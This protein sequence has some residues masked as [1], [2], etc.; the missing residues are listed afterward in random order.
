MAIKIGEGNS[1]LRKKTKVE[2][3]E[4]HT[5]TIKITGAGSRDISDRYKQYRR[6]IYMD[7]KLWKQLRLYAFNNEISVSKILEK[8]AKDYLLKEGILT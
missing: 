1:A 6:T 4:I 7:P 8:A 5:E 2:E 3:P